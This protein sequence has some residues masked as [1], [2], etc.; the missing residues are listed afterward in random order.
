MHRRHVKVADISRY[1]GMSRRCCVCVTLFSTRTRL[2][3]HLSDKRLRGSRVYNCRHVVLSSGFIEPVKED[4]YQ[5]AHM[6]DRENRKTARKRGHSQPLSTFCVKRAKIGMT[7]AECMKRCT[8][9]NDEVPSNFLEWSTVPP[10]KRVRY[11]SS[12]DFVM[13]QWVQ[14]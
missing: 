12:A 7:M 1:V 2:I 3:A 5:D 9:N 10:N 6:L 8:E 14:T 11:K 4:E 13:A